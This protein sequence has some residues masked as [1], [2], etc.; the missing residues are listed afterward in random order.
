VVLSKADLATRIPPSSLY[1]FVIVTDPYIPDDVVV[2]NPHDPERLFCFRL[3]Q[4]QAEYILNGVSTIG[5]SVNTMRRLEEEMER[6]NA[7]QEQGLHY[8]P[9]PSRNGDHR[10]QGQ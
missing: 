6:H 10:D 7:R 2:A 9:R 5:L 1:G 3:D 8:L 4:P